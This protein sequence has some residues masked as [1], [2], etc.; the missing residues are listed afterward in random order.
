MTGDK[1][2]NLPWFHFYSC[3]DPKVPFTL[4]CIV[5]IAILSFCEPFKTVCVPHSFTSCYKMLCCVLIGFLHLLNPLEALTCMACYQSQDTVTSSDKFLVSVPKA[6]SS[7]NF[8]LSPKSDDYLWIKT[9]GFVSENVW[10]QCNPIHCL[11]P[12][13]LKTLHSLHHPVQFQE[14]ST[15]QQDVVCYYIPLHY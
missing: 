1:Y 7:N 10:C 14:L 9:T 12:L 15:R 3:L 2:H 13:P 6:L 5:F 4:Q 8:V 11:L